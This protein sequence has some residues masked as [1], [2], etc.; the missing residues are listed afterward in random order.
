[1]PN[2]RGDSLLMSVNGD[3]FRKFIK[4]CAGYNTLNDFLGKME[5][6]NA[7][8][9]MKAFVIGLERTKE[10]KKQWMLP[11]P[12]AVSWIRTQSLQSLS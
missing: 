2:P 4:M 1:M 9:L 8:T 5:K 10:Q 3:Y 7:N 12:T 6:D 11:I